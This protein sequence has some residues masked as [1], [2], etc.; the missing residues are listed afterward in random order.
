M[1]IRRLL[2]LI[3]MPLALLSLTACGI[4]SVPR[5]E[6]SAQAK[7]ADVEAAYQRR[8]NLI[9]NLV[10]TVRGFADQERD[11]LVQ[12]TEARASASQVNLDAS[13]LGD[14]SA[15]AQFAEA[16]GELSG[17][18]SRLLVTFERYPE[19]RSSELFAN[20]STQLEG[21]ENR[22]TIAI[23]DYNESVRDYN[24]RL[25]TFPENIG[26]WLRGAEPMELYTATTP[27][28]EN[29]PEVDFSRE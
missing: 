23:R 18:L 9:P 5:A 15:M 28:A 27:G 22:I 3:F 29:A 12:V 14:A 4:N 25:R 21:T 10:E 8:A 1:H 6:E 16:Q 24:T 26:G 2:A 20:L 13:Q 7:W 19:L 17:A 11:V